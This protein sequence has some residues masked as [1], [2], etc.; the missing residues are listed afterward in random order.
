M[1]ELFRKRLPY[2]QAT[3]D[4]VVIEE[5]WLREL[6][7]FAGK[8][9][10]AIQGNRVVDIPPRRH[11]IR[12][13]ANF[14]KPAVLRAVSKI[15][16][17]SPRVAIAPPVGVGN[18]RAREI[19]RISEG[20]RG[21]LEDASDFRHQLF[22][23]YLWAACNGTSFLKTIFDPERGVPER[24][25]HMAKGDRRVIAEEFLSP[26][27]KRQRDAALLFDDYATGEV[28]TEA[29]SSFQFFH[30]RL[31]RTDLEHCRWAF[32]VQFI[33][34]DY[35]AEKF[36]V[37]PED[38]STAGQTSAL[39]RW[40][41]AL[42]LMTTST[43]SYYYNGVES[44]SEWQNRC[45]FAQMWERRSR[46][47]PRGRYCA[48]AGD[49]VLRDDNNPFSADINGWCEIP[50]T[51][52]DWCPMPGRFWSMG[53]VADLMAPQFRYN[54]SR[55][56]QAE[57]ERVHGRPSIFV[58]KDCGIPAGMQT[59]EPG[60]VYEYNPNI[61]KPEPGPVPQLPREVIENSNMARAEIA[62]LSAQSDLDSSKL[63]GQLR[64]GDAWDA[65]QRERDIT[66][67]VTTEGLLRTLRSWGRQAL[68]LAKIFYDT[69]RVAK[70]RGPSGNWAVIQ[71]QSADL[72]VDVRILGQPGEIE[73][74][75]S[76]DRRVQSLVQANVLNTQDPKIQTA[77]LKA[78]RFHTAEELID[79]ELQHETQQEEETRRMV[80][81]YQDYLDE[82]YPVLPFEDDAAHM[83][84]LIRLFT[85]LEE[86]DKL[87]DDQKAVLMAHWQLHSNQ[88]LQKT[89]QQVQLAQATQGTPG[90]RG[91]PSQPRA[92]AG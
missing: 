41:E 8:H 62:Q 25:Y 7:F 73:T 67:N 64:S 50:F 30:D 17:L 39:Q 44:D 33:D 85:D 71:F 22:M 75:Q 78:L 58:P 9:Y 68:S 80:A 91:Q 45:W 15:M 59:L 65:M 69:P 54:E 63:P 5:G 72:S 11:E 88:Q 42:A 35:V 13:K 16:E 46:A 1:L 77:V 38:I 20:V 12:Y 28:S 29:C 83:R 10:S 19:S 37:K 92:R 61:G 89:M 43:T 4:R 32:Q 14:V 52:V 87:N 40:E 84:V 34:R 26:E 18:A 36:G 23:A 81:N 27:D 24:F 3:G 48:V 47:H 53:L 76:E 82:V 21:H 90:A 49:T 60:A 51:K 2:R 79:D 6:C 56:R 57:F 55:A 86:M 66:L 70:Y 31:S 74:T